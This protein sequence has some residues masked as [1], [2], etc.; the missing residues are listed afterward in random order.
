MEQG[1][2]NVWINGRG[3]AYV[4]CLSVVCLSSVGLQLFFEPLV[5]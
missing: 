4:V 1:A 3:L 2:L 5:G